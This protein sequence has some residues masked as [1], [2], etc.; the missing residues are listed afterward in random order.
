MTDF[1]RMESLVGS[2]ET[3]IRLTAEIQD[4]GKLVMLRNVL[5]KMNE[6]HLH[7]VMTPLDERLAAHSELFTLH[8]VLMNEPT[9]Q[10]LQLEVSIGFPWYVDE[11]EALAQIT[12]L[13]VMVKDLKELLRGRKYSFE[14]I[15]AEAGIDL[16]EFD[17]GPYPTVTRTWI[18]MKSIRHR[19]DYYKTMGFSDHVWF[20][21]EITMRCKRI[22]IDVLCHQRCSSF[23][24]H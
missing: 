16:K 6:T 24:M 2:P 14:E 15:T 7:K 1:R 5:T 9:V 3:L 4:D 11:L 13:E 17:G 22:D 12:S 21:D 8:R 18:M 23:K 19:A 10:F 20:F